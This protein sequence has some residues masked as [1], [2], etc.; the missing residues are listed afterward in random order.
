MK[1]LL[2]VFARL[3]AKVV[4]NRPIAKCAAEVVELS[5]AT[6][7]MQPAAI[8]LPG[9]FDRVLAVQEETTLA[10][11]RERVT[12]CERRHGPTLAYRIDNAVLGEGTLYYDGGYDVIRSHSTGA[13]LRGEL[14]DFAEMQ[15]CVNYVIERYFGHWLVDGLCLELL[16][17]RRSMPGLALA[18]APWL[19]E[20]GYRE[21]VGLEVIRLRKARIRRLWVIDDRG[22]NDGWISRF[23]ELRSRVRLGAKGEGARRLMVTRGTLGA[24]RNLVN[25]SEVHA[26]L[27][28]IGFEIV[29]PESETPGSLV[30]KLAA[31][32]IVV[33]VEGSVQNHGLLAMPSGSIFV[34]IQPPDR[35]NAFAKAQADAAGIKW[36]YVVADSDPD[37][38]CLPVERLLRTIDE[39]TRVASLS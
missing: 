8:A 28:R 21:L 33:A 31:A 20:S 5:P 14:D 3:R 30:G 36:G 25:S 17:Q 23:Q 37:G 10:M 4:G 6:A 11:E 15:L 16:A 34:A 27:E 32:E 2:P 22:I 13:L 12:A 38:F 29:D 1:Q 7:R 9:E 35:F 39:A 26:A 18:R 19:H 24:K